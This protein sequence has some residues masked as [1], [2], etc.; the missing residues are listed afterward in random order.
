MLQPWGRLFVILLRVK[1]PPFTYHAPATVAEAVEVLS[2]VAPAGKVL[3]GGQSLIPILNM[4]LAAPAHIVDINRIAE[5]AAVDVRDDRVTVSAVARQTD[6]E[7]DDRIADVC[8][9]LPQALALVAHP[10]VR[11]RGTVV[12]SVVHADPA[13]ELPAVFALL[14]G[15]AHVVSATRGRDVPAAE[16]FVGPQDCEGPAQE[17]VTAVSFPAV[18]TDTGTAFLEVARR[19]GDYALGGVAAAVTV[20]GEGRVRRAR[21]AYTGVA[22]TPLVLDVT[23]PVEGRTAQRANYAKAGQ[24]AAEQVDPDAD[25]H[26]SAA[27]RRHLVGVLTERALRQAGRAALQRTGGIDG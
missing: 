26:A 5:L 8:P 17:L 21:A 20:N 27:Y 3:A 9:L 14:D 15:T 4:R 11:N 18:G 16:V 1:P 22:P 25:V 24:L 23:D 19:H 7:H 2:S 10:V 6:V 12:G 13:G